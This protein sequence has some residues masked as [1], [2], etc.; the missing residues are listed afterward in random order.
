MAHAGGRP[1]GYNEEIAEEICDAVSDT[2]K[3]LEDLCDE[4]D[5]WPSAKTI[6]KWRRKYAE[7]GQMYTRA[8][9]DQIEAL[10]SRAFVIARDR[11][12]DFVADSEG[13][14]HA[15]TPRVQGMRSEIDMIKWLAS[16]LAPKI[17]GERKENNIGAEGQSL[18]QNIIDKL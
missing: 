9:Q 17:Y 12:N 4:H 18:L 14:L 5:H 8:K 11:S 7:F 1:S 16:K 10:V 6:Y 2:P 3:M 15:N 13:K